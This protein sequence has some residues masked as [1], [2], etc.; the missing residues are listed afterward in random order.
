MAVTTEKKV[1]YKTPPGVTSYPHLF[2]ARPDNNGKMKYSVSLIFKG[3]K[4]I[5][6]LHKIAE[7]TIKK[8]FPN[9]KI[10]PRFKMPF[11][12]GGDYADK[13][14]YDAG[15]VFIRFSKIES[16]GP[17]AVVGPDKEPVTRADVYPGCIGIVAFTPKVWHFAESN[18][19]GLSFYLEAF[20]K[21]RD[22]EH[23]AGH[24]DVNPDEVFDIIEE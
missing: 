4:G 7:E 5:E 17:V 11:L 6:S 9:G 8:A 21:V 20:Q 22:G 24:E 3:G 19:R 14:G 13:E 1:R 12:D 10:P 18:T 15:D 2:E 23:L 16:F